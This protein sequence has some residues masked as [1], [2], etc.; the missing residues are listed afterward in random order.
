MLEKLNVGEECLWEGQERRFVYCNVVRVW[1][2]CECEREWCRW[3]KCLGSDRGL[4]GRYL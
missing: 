2:E 3:R 4:G 1:R